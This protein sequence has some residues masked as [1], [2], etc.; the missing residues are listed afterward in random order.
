MKSSNWVIG[1]LVV[2]LVVLGIAVFSKPK[3]VETKKPIKIGAVISL[4]G[5]A[6]STGE[7]S[8]KGIDLAVEEINKNGGIGGRPVE[9]VI[10]DDHTVAKDAATAFSKL[11]HVDN[12]D[13]VIG[14]LWDFTTQP[15]LSLAEANQIALITPTNP[16]IPNSFEL[17]KNSFAM[18]VNFEDII[19][20]LEDYL[21]EYKPKQMAIVR[22]TSDFGKEIETTLQ[23]ILSEHGFQNSLIAE[24]YGQIGG[25]DFRT[26]IL[27][28]K[29][30]GVDMVFLDMV[31]SDITSFLKRSRELNYHP[32][33]V[34]YTTVF[35]A[36]KALDV[37]KTLFE[38]VVVLDW[39][40]RQ[41]KFA[42]VFKDK[43]GTEPARLADKS[44]EAVYVLANAIANTNAR[45]E[46]APYIEINKF[47][48]VNGEISFT[49]D[50]V[51]SNTPVVIEIIRSG[52]LELLQ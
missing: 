37:D 51:V 14:S 31:D 25:N 28:L 21:V 4:S 27:K 48:T 17:G 44:Y 32:Q 15:L 45:A 40:V 23:K 52:K 33:V 24:T 42:E 19:R 8:K 13:A 5:F 43:Y 16:R 35:D 6:A 2:V 3:T 50:H 18:L 20:T 47:E 11:V 36:L 30:S 41:E 46:V 12:V 9:V 39:E 7:Y 10:E 29:T 22:F 34:V 38:N 49:K 1:I 26:T